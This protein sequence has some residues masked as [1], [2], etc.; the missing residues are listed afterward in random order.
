M[1]PAFRLSTRFAKKNWRYSYADMVGRFRL[2]VSNP[3]LK[4]RMLSALG[5]TIR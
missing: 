5:A 4:A 3:V 2:T 1:R